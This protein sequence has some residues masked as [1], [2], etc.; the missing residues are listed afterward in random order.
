M[1]RNNKAIIQTT[2]I[3]YPLLFLNIKGI[4][5]EVE[6]QKWE[7]ASLFRIDRDIYSY[8]EN[9]EPERIELP[10]PPKSTS[11][12]KKFQLNSGQRFIKD[13]NKIGLVGWELVSHISSTD[14]S[15]WLFKR[16]IEG[17]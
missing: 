10:N 9:S 11:E 14:Y 5:K 12:L 7:Y 1:P 13:I 3:N 6:T 15:E 4:N 16:P 2:L 8:Q 17:K